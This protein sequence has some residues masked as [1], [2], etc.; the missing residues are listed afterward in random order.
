MASEMIREAVAIT[1]KTWDVAPF[2]TYVACEKVRSTNPGYC[3]IKAGFVRKGYKERT[4]HGRMARLEMDAE[5]VSVCLQEWLA[6][7]SVPA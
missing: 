4:K 2:I 7:L 1:A 3:F 6:S 5:E